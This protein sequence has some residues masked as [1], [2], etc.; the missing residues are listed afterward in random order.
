MF[1][2]E[3]LE[4]KTQKLIKIVTYRGRKRT[5]GGDKEGS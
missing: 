5:E 1:Q 3:I 2:K 4:E